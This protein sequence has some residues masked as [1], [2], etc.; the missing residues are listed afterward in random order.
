MGVRTYVTNQINKVTGTVEIFWIL[1][2]L[3][4]CAASLFITRLL[5]LCHASFQFAK[6][7]I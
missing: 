6:T 3:L 1:L 4:C 5:K 2:N 7:Q